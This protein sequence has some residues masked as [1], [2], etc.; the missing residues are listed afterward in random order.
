MLHTTQFKILWQKILEAVEI[1]IF[2]TLDMLIL[3]DSP[4]EKYK[5]S[6]QITWVFKNIKICHYMTLISHSDSEQLITVYD[7]E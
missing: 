5:N 2:K 6:Q 7:W 3:G 1:K 4:S